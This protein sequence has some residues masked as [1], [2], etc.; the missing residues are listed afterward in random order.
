MP[1]QTYDDLR[2]A[3]GDAGQQVEEAQAALRLAEVEAEA[4][5]DRADGAVRAH[6]L[7][8]GALAD[9]G[10][11]LTTTEGERE[12]STARGEIGGLHET[13]AAA[14]RDRDR[15]R[16]DLGEALAIGDLGEARAE[17]FGLRDQ[18]EQYKRNA[19]VYRRQDDAFGALMAER[20]QLAE[21]L[22]NIETRVF[23]LF[24]GASADA[25]DLNAMTAVQ[26]TELVRAAIRGA[27][28]AG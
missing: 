19:A 22:D 21:Q 18:M 14:D 3:L 6:D 1:E 9:M 13:I 10:K 25:M 5:K 27:D 20:D 4:Q 28:D 12:L 26:L 16:T 8:A 24:I 15:L 23:Q 7:V 11:Q 17:I 2:D